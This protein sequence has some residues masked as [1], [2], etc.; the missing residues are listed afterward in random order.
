MADFI[1][2]SDI[3]SRLRQLHEKTG[4][5]SSEFCGEC[6]IPTSTYSQIVNGKGRLNVETINKVVKR[7]GGEYDPM[8]LLFGDNAPGS[9]FNSAIEGSPTHLPADMPQTIPELVDEIVRLRLELERNKPRQVSKIVV[10]HTD[11]SYDTYC[12]DTEE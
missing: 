11:K 8:W 1:N 5:T 3:A 6:E 2:L 10:Y 4:L 9:F 12:L 7:W